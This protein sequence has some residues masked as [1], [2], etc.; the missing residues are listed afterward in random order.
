VKKNELMADLR[1]K[2]GEELKAEIETLKR[3]QFVERSSTSTTGEKK[4]SLTRLRNARKEIARIL[5][6]LRERELEEKLREP[7]I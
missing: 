7:L 6:I 2:S 3:V 4:G 1:K 5:T